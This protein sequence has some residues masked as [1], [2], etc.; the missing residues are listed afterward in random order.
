[1]AAT[2]TARSPI[3]CR[4]CFAAPWTRIR[5]ALRSP[6]RWRTPTVWCAAASWRRWLKASAFCFASPIAQA[7][8][9]SLSRR[10]PSPSPREERGEG[11]AGPRRAS[12]SN[13]SRNALA[14]R[15]EARQRFA[16]RLAR[17]EGA[18]LGSAVAIVFH[19]VADV[20]EIGERRILRQIEAGAGALRRPL[21]AHDPHRQHFRVNEAGEQ[22]TQ[23]GERGLDLCLLV[24]IAERRLRHGVGDILAPT[25]R[26]E[27]GTGRRE[28]AHV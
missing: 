9:P 15:F 12:D 5:W 4:C 3:S 16:H 18:G 14:R 1:P 19:G 11:S 25:W 17:G 21:A 26:G 6:R 7:S 10:R 22:R 20:P 24:E 23:I 2:P 13:V 27:F 8:S 28:F